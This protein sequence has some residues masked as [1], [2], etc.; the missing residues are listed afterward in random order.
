MY[1]TKHRDCVPRSYNGRRRGAPTQAERKR[2][3]AVTKLVLVAYNGTVRSDVR[4]NE[5]IH[6]PV[7]VQ[8]SASEAKKKKQKANGMQHQVVSPDFLFFYASITTRTDS[9]VVI[10]T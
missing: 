6:L 4:K 10:V 9:Y 5:G 8:P 2:H 1:D 3:R 7:L